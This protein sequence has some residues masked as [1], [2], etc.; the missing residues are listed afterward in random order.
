MVF[1]VGFLYKQQPPVFPGL[2]A[3]ARAACHSVGTGAQVGE[4]AP[5]HLFTGLGCTRSIS[6]APLRAGDSSPVA[7]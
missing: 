5:L 4:E 2:G 6:A 1:A 7:E 3:E